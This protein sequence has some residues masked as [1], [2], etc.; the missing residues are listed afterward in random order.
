M[1]ALSLDLSDTAA[2]DLKHRPL[3][4]TVFAM[5]ADQ[6]RGPWHRQP[7]ARADQGVVEFQRLNVRSATVRALG[8]VMQDSGPL[9]CG[10]ESAA[11]NRCPPRCGERENV[12]AFSGRGNAG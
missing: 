8:I 4:A 12:G 6:R 7:A 5:K 11:E 2:T 3:A 10:D 9:E 1:K